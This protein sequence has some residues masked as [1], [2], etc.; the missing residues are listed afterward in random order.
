MKLAQNSSYGTVK[1]T[2][3][4]SANEVVSGRPRLKLVRNMIS[5]IVIKHSRQGRTGATPPLFGL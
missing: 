4:A 3:M 2:E 5:R 1:C